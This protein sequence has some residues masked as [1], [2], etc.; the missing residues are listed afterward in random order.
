LFF[1]ITQDEPK[2]TNHDHT[3]I[4]RNKQLEEINEKLDFQQMNAILLHNAL[5]NK[6]DVL[7]NKVDYLNNQL[8]MVNGNFMKL[9]DFSNQIFISGINSMN[10]IQKKKKK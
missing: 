8:N 9:I 6:L 7:I 5:S 3:T 2:T 10:N 1:C 4:E